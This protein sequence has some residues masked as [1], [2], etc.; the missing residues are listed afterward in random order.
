MDKW[1][2]LESN[3]EQLTQ[4]AR[5]LGMKE[6]LAFHDVL[7]FDEEILAMVP[8]PRF[9]VLFCYPLDTE[10]K[11]G[12]KAATASNTS[13]WFTKQLVPNACGT[14]GLIH[15]LANTDGCLKEDDCPLSAFLQRVQSLSADER[16]RAMAEDTSLAQ[17]HEEAAS[18][19]DSSVPGRDEDV[20]LH[21]VCFIVCNG[22][23]YEL[24]A[25]RYSSAVTN[26]L[27]S[28]SA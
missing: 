21:F 12:S 6:T 20:S 18:G 19:G 11:S 17:A 9:A 22:N 26:P 8:H 10:P 2:P 23:L 13:T 5:A 7:G 16:A 24:G 25:Y 28:P 15:A 1:L 4:A 3:P 27:L 14:V